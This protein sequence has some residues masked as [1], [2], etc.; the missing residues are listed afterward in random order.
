MHHAPSLGPLRRGTQNAPLASA[1]EIAGHG[2]RRPLVRHR[3]ALVDDLVDHTGRVE[4]DP[5]FRPERQ[6]G[7]LSVLGQGGQVGE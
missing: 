1:D 5:G 3:T 6:R 2:H 4:E 7:H